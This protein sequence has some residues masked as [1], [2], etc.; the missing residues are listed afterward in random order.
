M[1]DRVRIDPVVRLRQCERV[2]HVVVVESRLDRIADEQL[3]PA[4][5]APELREVP[6]QRAARIVG[7]REQQI[8]ESTPADR[9]IGEQ[10]VRQDGPGLRA[11]RGPGGS[12]VD[13]DSRRTQQP[14]VS[15]HVLPPSFARPPWRVPAPLDDL[16][17]GPTARGE[18]P[19]PSVR[20]K[21][22]RPDPVIV[23]IADA[24]RAGAV[25]PGQDIH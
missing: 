24:D 12:S 6:A 15:R 16:T 25:R 11:A 7:V 9:T 22:G 4:E 19:L 3:R 8:H 2:D 10:D 5:G 1:P 14:Y 20:W 17:V 21:A 13:L 23:S 18:S